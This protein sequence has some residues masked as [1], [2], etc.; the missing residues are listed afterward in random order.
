MRFIRN[1]NRFLAGVVAGAFF[2]TSTFMPAP[3]AYA[4]N[5]ESSAFIPSFKIPEEFGKITGI[6]PAFPS[7]DEVNT[8]DKEQVLIHIQ[9]AHANYDAQKNI[10]NILQYLS[11]SYGLKLI[12]VEG[13]GGKLQP[14]L[15]RFFPKDAELQSAVNDNL[16]KAGEL[17]GAEVFLIDQK[18]QFEFQS[19][20]AK[21]RL[22]QFRLPFI[23]E[24]LKS[25]QTVAPSSNPGQSEQSGNWVSALLSGGETTE[26]YGIE[27]AEAYGKNREAYKKVYEGRGTADTFL[28]DAY[29]GWQKEASLRLNPGLRDILTRYADFEERT[30]SLESWLETLK[31][32]SQEVLQTD[33]TDVTAQGAWPTLVRYF[34]LRALD[35]KIDSARAEQEKEAFMKSL[36]GLL[37][38]QSSKSQASFEQSASRL[39][40][41]VG[42]IFE[43]A[44]KNDLPVYKTRFVFERLMDQ[45]PAGFSFETYPN[46]RLRIQQMILMSELQSDRLQEEIKKIT[47]SLV[48]ALAKADAE[49]ALVRALREYQL[50]R[51]LFHLE[52]SRE[53]YQQILTREITPEKLFQGLQHRDQSRVTQNEGLRSQV[54][55]LK[56]LYGEAMDFYAGAIRR[57]DFMMKR[58][59]EVMKERKQTKA[60]IITGGFHTDGFK[61]KITASGSSYI[62]ITP[63]IGEIA[64]DSNKNYLA[65]LLGSDA[66]TRSHIAPETITQSSFFKAVS[67]RFWRREL[68]FRLSRI[69]GIVRGTIA[70]FKDRADEHMAEF[71][72]G[73]RILIAFSVETSSQP[74]PV[75]R[76]ARS[77]VRGKSAK[78]EARL[79]STPELASK[80]AWDIYDLSQFV[81]ASKGVLVAPDLKNIQEGIATHYLL[82]GSRGSIGVIVYTADSG[83]V[84]KVEVIRK[85]LSKS[86]FPNDVYGK[87]ELERIDAVLKKKTGLGRHRVSD[88]LE[89][90]KKQILERSVAGDSRDAL[91]KQFESAQESIAANELFEAAERVRDIAL[92]PEVSQRTRLQPGRRLFGLAKTLE[93]FSKPGELESILRDEPARI[94]Q[95]IQEMYG[96]SL[97][98][99]LIEPQ[100]KGIDAMLHWDISL[101][102]Y[103]LQNAVKEAIDQK[104]L[105]A[106]VKSYLGVEQDE[107]MAALAKSEDVNAHSMASFIHHYA[108][109]AALRKSLARRSEVRT[110]E[111]LAAGALAL[112]SA[113]KT[114]YVDLGNGKTSLSPGTDGVSLV[115]LIK[116]T[117]GKITRETIDE[118]IRAAAIAAL[119]SNHHLT[120]LAGLAAFIG[121]MPTKFSKGVRAVVADGRLKSYAVGAAGSAFENI[122]PVF[123]GGKLTNRL[124]I[125]QAMIRV[126]RAANPKRSELRSYAEENAPELDDYTVVTG[127]LEAGLDREILKKLEEK[128][129]KTIAGLV[130]ATTVT[131]GLGA[132]MHDL[133][134]SWQKNFGQPKEKNIDAFAVNVIYD[135]IKGQEFAKDLPEEVTSGKKTLGD[136]LREVLTEDPKLSFSIFPD[137]GSEYRAKAEEW[138]DRTGDPLYR[139]RLQQAREAVDR[140]IKVKVY[141]TETAVG[142]MP[143][144]YIEAFYIADDGTKVQ[145]FDEVYPDSPQGTPNLW[146]DLHLAVYGKTKELLTLKLQEKGIVKK[147]ILFVDNEVFASI[148]TPLFPDALHHHM[149]HSVYT[150]TIYWP[151]AASFQLL[152][153][154]EAM[155]SR[156]VRNGRI[157]I[158]DAVGISYDLVTGVALYEHT[159]AV[160]GG[161]MPGYIDVIDHY[162][163]D[164]LRSTNGVLLEQWQSPLFRA[165]IDNYKKK[166]GLDPKTDDRDF[167]I[168]LRYP[169]NEDL[170]GE[171]KERFDMIK[172][173]LAGRLMLWLKKS[174]SKPKWF[175]Q[176]MKAYQEE[177]KMTE[178][179]GPKVMR[180]LYVRIKKALEDESE[181]KEIFSDPQAQALRKQFLL[182]A[183]VSNV[184]RQVSYKGPVKWLEILRSLEA[185]PAKL[186]DYKKNAARAI[187]GGREFGEEAHELFLEIQRLIRA[188][189][190]E[191]KFATIENYNIKDAPIIFQGVSGTNM[192]TYMILE[193]SATSNMKGLP[194]GAILMGSWGGS[195]PELFTIVDNETGREKD[196]FRDKITYE[197]M[198]E[199]LKSRKWKIT[200]GFLVLYSKNGDGKFILS[201]IGP[202]G[203]IKVIDAPF[204]LAESMIEDLKALQSAYA[205]SSDRMNLQWEALRSSPLVDM[206]KSQA[207]AHIKL[208]QRIIQKSMKQKALLAKTGLSP[209]RALK[210]LSKKSQSDGGFFWRSEPSN[211][212]EIAPPGVLAFVESSRKVR[213]HGTESYKSI[214]YHAARGEI[215]AK[216]LYHLD[217]FKEEV[218]DLYQEMSR[219]KQAAAS[220]GDL[221]EKVRIHQA[222]L[223]LFDRFVV[224]LSETVLRGYIQSR[225]SEYEKL[226]KDE[227]FRQNLYF[228]LETRGKRFGFLNQS[229]V[230]FAVSVGE[231]KYV[232]AL[233]LGEQKYPSVEA[234]EPKAWGQFYGKNAF[235]WL[236]SQDDPESAKTYLFRNAITGEVYGMGEDRKPYPFP[237]LAEGALPIGVGALDIQI[238]EP[239]EAGV[240]KQEEKREQQG[241]QIADDLRALVSGN[242]WEQLRQQK[243]R[244]YWLRQRIQRTK[245]EELKPLLRTV[246]GMG[247]DKAHAVFGAEGIRPVMAFI[248]TLVP[249]LLEDMKEWDSEVYGALKGV[250][251]NSETKEFFEKGEVVFLN[252][253]RDTAV[254]LARVLKSET[255]PPKMA[256]HVVVPIHFA[257]VP[258]NKEEGKVWFGI[259]SIALLGLA[260][261]LVYQ[262]QDHLLQLDYEKRHT[263]EALLKEGWRVGIS[264]VKREDPAKI[265]QLGWRFQVL[266]MVP[267]AVTKASTPQ[268][269]EAREESEE[270]SGIDGIGKEGID[271]ETIARELKEKGHSVAF[272]REDMTWEHMAD[273]I[274]ANQVVYF[275]PRLDENY[276]Y[277][278][279]EARA[280]QMAEQKMGPA[281]GKVRRDEANAVKK[282]ERKVF[283]FRG[284]VDPD[285]S[286]KLYDVIKW[287]AHP[288]AKDDLDFDLVFQPDFAFL[289]P[290]TGKNV[291]PVVVFGLMPEQS[292]EFQQRTKDVLGRIFREREER[293]ELQYMNIRSAEMAKEMLLIY[294]G[295]KLAHFDDIAELSR[296]YGAD[297]SAA[298]FGAGLDKRIRT[299]FTN[300]SLGFGKRLFVYLNWIYAQR[301][302][303]AALEMEKHTGQKLEEH[304]RAIEAQVQSAVQQLQDGKDIAEILKTLPPQLHLL[305]V[306]KN[307]L[308]INKQ[309]I[310]DFYNVIVQE[311]ERMG[312]GALRGKKVALLSVG[313]PS[314]NEQLAASPALLL[315]D[316]LFTDHGIVEFFVADPAAKTAFEAWVRKKQDENP[317]FKSVKFEFV[318]DIYAAAQAAD[319]VVIPGDSNAQLKEIQID[320]FAAALGN[321]PVFDGMNLFGLRADGTSIYKLEDVRR[322]NINLIGVGRLPLGPAFDGTSGYRL[323]DSTVIRTLEDYRQKLRDLEPGDKSAGPFRQKTVTMV[324]GGYVGLVT[325]ANLAE[326]GHRVNVVDIKAKQ[327]E[328]DALAGSETAVPIYEPG[329]RE[330]IIEG[331]RKG[332]ITFFTDL[333]TAV[334]DS[335]IVYLAVGTPSQETGEVDL[336][337]ILQASADV[338][339]VIHKHGGFKAM[340]IK[341]TVTPDTFKRMDEVLSAKGLQLG[342]DYA[343]VSNPEF[344]REGQAIEDV[345]KPDRAVFGFYAGLNPEDRKRA[346]KEILELWY[347]LMERSSHTVLL[348]DTAS[349][350]I[351]KYLANSYLAI[352]ITLSNLFAASAEWDEA[353]FMEVKSPL[354]RDPRIGRN[355]FL[356]PGAGYGGSC[357]HKDVLA[358][359]FSSS[360]STGHELPLISIAIGFNDFYKKDIVRRAIAKAAQFPG[361]AQ[362]LEEKSVIM[363]GMAFKSD[364]DDMREASS[365]YILRELLSKGASRVVL[366]DPIL[367]MP[368]VPA[369]AVVIEHFLD[370]VYKTFRNEAEFREGFEKYNAHLRA[371][372]KPVLSEAEYFKKVYFDQKYIKTGRVVFQPDIAKVGQADIVFLVTEWPR[373]KNADVA[374]MKLQGR[375]FAV[376]DGRNLFYDRRAEMIRLGLYLG[377]GTTTPTITRSESRALA[378]SSKLAGVY[379]HDDTHKNIILD[380]AAAAAHGI[381]PGLVIEITTHLNAGATVQLTK[382][383][384]FHGKLSGESARQG[385]HDHTEIPLSFIRTLRV[386]QL[387]A[388]QEI[389]ARSQ[390]ELHL[391][392]RNRGQTL[393]PL[394]VVPAKPLTRS[395]ARTADFSPTFFEILNF[396]K[397]FSLEDFL[398]L[399]EK[400]SG[401][402]RQAMARV[403][404]TFMEGVVPLLASV[405]GSEVLVSK[406]LP[407]AMAQK[408]ITRTQQA[409]I[410]K[411]LKRLGVLTLQGY[412]ALILTKEFAFDR[413]ALLAVQRAFSS[414]PVIVLA[415]EASLSA[416][417][418]NFLNA[419]F[420]KDNAGNRPLFLAPTGSLPKAA[421]ALLNKNNLGRGLRLK[422]MAGV[423]D[424]TAD[425]LRQQLGDELIRLMDAQF[426][427]FLSVAG[428]AQ[429]VTQMQAE[430]LAT[431][432]SV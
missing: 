285:T 398:K 374:G 258:Y 73:M 122:L 335:S 164:G 13:A 107:A 178:I 209:E 33:L 274:G 378:A 121:G 69:S 245:S 317:R 138:I 328:I 200:N 38:E 83:I 355:A 428:L 131:G 203:Q 21:R 175:D 399:Y 315:I 163:Q 115:E 97:E 103:G 220:T 373:Y 10:R 429:L 353:D 198:I 376:I 228:L 237:M 219:L 64:T 48:E 59:R 165:L 250:M 23:R 313:T 214:E 375:P 381:P 189:K 193:A 128:Y 401:A 191:D 168:K 416:A 366:H 291:E 419:L 27:N 349:A 30:V 204:P 22:G 152:G 346:E 81:L 270:F 169:G 120:T 43:K 102:I 352:S 236:L 118:V 386:V 199:N 190:L 284:M 224:Q 3:V 149:N 282:R 133:F 50:L 154:P 156:I 89:A 212:L 407:S 254:V 60:V 197:K 114:G 263:L 268:R 87:G 300:P 332:L 357:F 46:L 304:K 68:A 351:V 235:Q 360:K 325:A 233:N 147:K 99:A 142:G 137:A 267:G 158:V 70:F 261:G 6:I 117:S 192:I 61:E 281:L 34:R 358:L 79:E 342:R 308:R 275:A 188:L 277:A 181:W 18:P 159:P 283:V 410:D 145:I 88:R 125:A 20:E 303:K 217:E 279:Y 84:K 329:L 320:Q 213:T 41:E 229:L 422:A 153:Y 294:L 52:L 299:L 341:S 202:D 321:K 77:E 44:K 40:Q 264:V 151:D 105:A 296:A 226:F 177:F 423:N 173:Y 98:E 406:L 400:V 344:L 241:S 367:S 339:D 249:E 248:A 240:M 25:E 431:S 57:E 298:A 119:F 15:F 238:L 136:Y 170:L 108:M 393:L 242:A 309:N 307:I 207:R 311:Y 194:N 239:Q 141:R 412:D 377:V 17:T 101:R 424:T 293:Q 167:F 382:V 408:M 92:R 8:A 26:A 411:A 146:R 231:K 45:L 19:I 432:R 54:S 340:V 276:D 232:V 94:P 196:I 31:K 417:D 234:G 32:S 348:T 171:F 392:Q 402:R 369:P 55:S 260:A 9:E 42:A 365:V 110:A 409:R 195:E 247:R 109:R 37:K 243:P 290:Q 372:V 253:S 356:A 371:E 186:A 301:L 29:L 14:E 385:Y 345:T 65:A 427:N 326:L 362:P 216:I 425:L 266:Q 36:P 182:T 140:E 210:F 415:D 370:Y 397:T 395:E 338:G 58:A 11:K 176:A 343:P 172:S 183:I 132:L 336:K 404:A 380:F 280:I 347:P 221:L 286:E 5:V 82:R 273:I 67:P 312:N 184:R 388:W 414:M 405:S 426:Q 413:K 112:Y 179:S 72:A 297:L 187:L 106:F 289:D 394:E 310:I 74:Q 71:D 379:R 262:T 143:N 368:N 2:V 257:K 295:A 225:N 314:G 144:F 51:K 35:G 387:G 85:G 389:S 148:P 302:Y 185:D 39:A 363:L 256:R 384:V 104:K 180:E 354:L 174:Q 215:F 12:L 86:V 331:K 318:K 53:E 251:E 252:A 4:A 56:P 337:Y 350:T 327:K 383:Q 269:S 333:E 223:R 230:G 324:G 111:E 201:T 28:Y 218:P 16:L 135:R 287:N 246:S 24:N 361:A 421:G 160:S 244:S 390:G 271:G 319:L 130:A 66:I 7:G 123:A 272:I 93:I 255:D 334:K 211:S 80:R 49:K 76:S 127:Q 288:A 330:M 166:L 322:A 90:I 78:T 292:P 227:L 95:L 265:A 157:S 305:F 116:P 259:G 206:E 63:S 403:T 306:L 150:P 208:W 205:V 100:E 430:Y 396:K 162:N 222:A 364:T 126:V 359:H 62:G 139:K 155:R 323:S 1:C 278:A 75:S 161:V 418:R 47:S 316:K 96:V 113:N 124:D 129:G 391:P 91:S 420:G 134:P